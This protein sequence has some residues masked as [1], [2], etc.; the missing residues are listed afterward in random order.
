MA[1]SV[2]RSS[3]G[4][5]LKTARNHLGLTMRQVEEASQRIAEKYGIEDYTLSLARISDF[6]NSGA[7]PTLHKLYSLCAIYRLDMI[8][9]MRWYGIDAALTPSDWLH[10]AA[11]ATYTA[12]T[13]DPGPTVEAPV[14]LDPFVTHERTTYLSRMV[15]KWGTIPL[16]IL[17]GQDAKTRRYGFIGTEDRFMYPLIP[18]GSF[19]EIDPNRAEIRTEPWPSEYERP[20]YFVETKDGYSCGWCTM[21]GDRLMLVPHPLSGEAPRSFAVTDARVLGQVN[22][23]GMRLDH[24][25]GRGGQS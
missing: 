22:G 24:V 11:P 17:Q 3:A 12:Q 1:D 10:A 4:Q 18:P 23:I 16:V 13:P 21:D 15:Q 14:S 2:D 8:E 25:K 5:N 7:V 9:V 6:E 19:V 20:I